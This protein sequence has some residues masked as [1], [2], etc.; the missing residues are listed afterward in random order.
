MSN[1]HYTL[2]RLYNCGEPREWC[3]TLYRNGVLLLDIYGDTEVEAQANAEAILDFI[4]SASNAPDTSP[5]PPLDMPKPVAHSA[6]VVSAEPLNESLESEW[7]ETC[8]SWHWSPTCP[9]AP[10][11]P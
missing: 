4:V 8:R 3:V 10:P 11:T 5:K 1:R 9:Y 7:C 2:G 6:G